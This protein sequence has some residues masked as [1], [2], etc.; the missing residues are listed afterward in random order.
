MPDEEVV[1]GGEQEEEPDE[2]EDLDEATRK[3]ELRGGDPPTH[4]EFVG[5]LYYRQ[6]ALCPYLHLAPTDGVRGEVRD[7]MVGDQV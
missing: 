2:Q 1:P 3:L 7:I 4:V 5:E 6:M